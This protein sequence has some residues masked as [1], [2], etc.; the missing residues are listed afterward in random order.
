MCRLLGVLS[1]V[2]LVPSD[3]LLRAP[4]SLYQQS[5]VDKNRKQGDGWGMGWFEKGRPTLFK[6]PRA[7]YLD[8]TRWQQS[9]RRA[10]G[11][12]LVGHVR[13]ASNPL[14]LPRHELIGLPHTQ[15][16][17]HGPWLFAHNGTLYIPREVR[18]E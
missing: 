5:H 17:A 14:K 6:S 4:H 16:F 9:A 15:P 7:L 18:A 1:D 3:Y 2:D 11:K 12:V 8:R 10:K 13:W